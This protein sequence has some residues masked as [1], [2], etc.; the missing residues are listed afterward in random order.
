GGAPVNRDVTLMQSD[1]AEELA[2][3]Y[4]SKKSS[5]LLPFLILIFLLV[6][7]GIGGAIWYGPGKVIAQIT[8][9]EVKKVELTARDRANE[10]YLRGS[11]LFEEKKYKKAIKAFSKAIK[12]DPEYAK[13]H[14]SLAIVLAQTKKEKAAVASYKRYLELLPDAPD[15]VKVRKIVED[16]E[17]ANP[18]KKSKEE[19][20]KEKKAEAEKKKAEAEAEK[21]KAEAEKDK[22][23]KKRRKKR[24]RR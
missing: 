10:P 24:R 12:I 20:A 3:S 23:K 9:S 8:G 13:A 14:R 2:E 16:W 21:K 19:L 7:G 17:K 22:K 1:L 4:K 11:K 6:G 5:I 15:A 18:P